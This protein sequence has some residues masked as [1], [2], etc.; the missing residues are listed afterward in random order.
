MAPVDC[1]ADEHYLESD[2]HPRPDYFVVPSGRLEVG[3]FHRTASEPS[4]GRWSW[5][6]GIGTGEPWFHNSWKSVSVD[7]N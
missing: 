2:G 1:L 6:R 3:G 5:L 4:D 7:N